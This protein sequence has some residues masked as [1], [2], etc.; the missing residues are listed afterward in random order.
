MVKILAASDIHSDI[1]L[2]RRLADKAEKNKANLVLLCG[3]ITMFGDDAEGLI[4][5][6]KKKNIEVLMVHGNHEDVSLTDFLSQKYGKG[7]Y[8]LH[9]YYK[10]FNNVAIMGFGGIEWGPNAN[11]DELFN[12]LKKHFKKTKNKKKVLITHEPPYNTKLDDLGWTKAGSVGLRRFIETYS[13]DYVIC[14]HIHETFGQN[15]KINRTKIINAGRE[16][17]ILDL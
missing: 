14:G 9:T 11:K 12:T 17:I 6:F 15:D 10:I 13:P 3:D 16:G 2:A 5:P 7:I 1:K 4:G 8:N